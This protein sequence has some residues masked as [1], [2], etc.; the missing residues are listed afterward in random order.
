MGKGLLFYQ[1]H[2]IIM[3]TNEKTNAKTSEV[4]QEYHAIIRSITSITLR[5]NAR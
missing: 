3:H 2:C 4:S 5:S 1:K